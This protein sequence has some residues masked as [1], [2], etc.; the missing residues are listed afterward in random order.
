MNHQAIPKEN[1][2]LS[3]IIPSKIGW[4]NSIFA[5]IELNMG[6]KILNRVKIRIVLSISCFLIIFL[7]KNK[8]I[9]VKDRI[10]SK[11]WILKKKPCK[12][13]EKNVPETRKSTIG[14]KIE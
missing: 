3:D 9:Y 7:M 14:I 1:Q 5:L 4:P 12:G 8:K 2:P 10:I 13:V 11:V 6:M